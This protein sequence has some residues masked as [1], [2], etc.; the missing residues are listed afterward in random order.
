MIYAYI[1]LC[2]REE[3]YGGYWE[4][5]EYLIFTAYMN[6]FKF[7]TAYLESNPFDSTVILTFYTI[8]LVV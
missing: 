2:K 3:P 6:E 4:I 5:F 8:S 1:M 7:W